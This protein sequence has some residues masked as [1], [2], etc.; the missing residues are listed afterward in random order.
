MLQELLDIIPKDPR[1]RDVLNQ[2]HQYIRKN[3]LNLGWKELLELIKEW[4]G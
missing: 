2:I 3:K 4:L 1:I